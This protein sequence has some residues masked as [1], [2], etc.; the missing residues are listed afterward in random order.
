M[1][2]DTSQRAEERPIVVLG[3]PMES[4][5][6]LQGVNL[7]PAALRAAGLIQALG[8]DDLGD[9]PISITDARRD[10][11]SGLIAFDQ[12][13]AATGVV[14]DAVLGLLDREALPLVVGGCCGILVGIFAALSAIHDRVGLAFIDGHYDFYDGATSPAGALADMELR[15]LTG[16]GPAALVEAGSRRP[17]LEPRDAWVLAYRDAWEMT[18][19]GAPDPLSEIA[20]AHFFDDEAVKASGPATIGGQA[21]A[22]L[23]ADPGH[24]WVHVDLDALSS[25]AMPAVDYLLPGGLDWSELTAL[26]RPLAASPALL[27]VDVTI[28]NPS[29]DPQRRLAPRIVRMLAEGLGIGVA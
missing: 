23:A 13:C 20:A 28:Y 9:L 7:M 10:P 4:E 15:V 11:E 29:L 16:A 5:A 1:K 27:G 8:A 25:E 6:L 3:A 17:L 22:A 18:A 21:A 12:V 24:F 26:L 19:A 14:R 2:A